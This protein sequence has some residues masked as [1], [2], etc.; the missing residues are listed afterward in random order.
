MKAEINSGVL[1]HRYCMTT[2]FSSYLFGR[3]SLPELIEVSDLFPREQINEL[4]RKEIRKLMDQPITQSQ[5]DDLESMLKIDFVSYIDSSLRRSGFLDPERD[6]L[7]HQIIVKLLVT[8]SFFRGYKNQSL[9]GRFKLSVHNMI[10]TF[11]TRRNRYRKR[12]EDLPSNVESPDEKSFH[13]SY[14]SDFADWIHIR[15]GDLA[16]KVFNHRMNGEDTKDLI[17]QPGLESAWKVK[18]I[19]AAIKQAAEEYAKNDPVLLRNIRNS[20]SEESE[21]LE[22]KLATQKTISTR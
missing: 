7:V 22:K 16:H 8:G 17:G 9:V 14:I 12:S 1:M 10:N 2:T 15:L 20:L 13:T 19:V 6:E 21:R 4:F 3:L 11:A 18:R 5:R